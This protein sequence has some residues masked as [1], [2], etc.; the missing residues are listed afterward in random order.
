MLRKLLPLLFGAMPIMAHAN[1]EAQFWNWF[2]A[3][4]SALYRFTSPTDPVLDQ[5]GSQLKQV[6]EDLT[7]ELGPVQP[8]GRRE[9]IISADGLKAAF[10]A[11]E[12]LYAA[13]P[14]LDLW[15]VVKY[16]PRRSPVNTLTLGEHTFDPAT[17]RCLLAKDGAKIGIV[18]MYDDYKQNDA[19]FTQASYLLLDDALGEY[20]VETQVGF[21]SVRGMEDRWVKQSFPMTR[22]AAEF[23][24]A[25]QG[26]G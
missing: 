11:V 3:N 19:L 4:Q 16:R 25:K 22:L 20:A 7:F 2:V 10:P 5:L 12:A 15:Q 8:E 21:V 18:L 23:D 6:N 13:A 14:K 1:Q 26:G 24:H 17:V 9:F